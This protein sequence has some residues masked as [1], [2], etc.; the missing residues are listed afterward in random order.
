MSLGK[1]E[2]NKTQLFFF[3]YTKLLIEEN[4]ARVRCWFVEMERGTSEMDLVY[5]KIQRMKALGLFEVSTVSGGR[6]GFQ[7]SLGLNIL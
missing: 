6:T 5:Y 3:G 2:L 4:K 7:N 1:I